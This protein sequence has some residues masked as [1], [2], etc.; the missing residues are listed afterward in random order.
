MKLIKLFEGQ[1]T[2]T[3]CQCYRDCDCTG[4]VH[5]Y[6]GVKYQKPNGQVR[7]KEFPNLEKR[8]EFINKHFNQ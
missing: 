6:F 2:I 8:Q 4:T 3:I 5:K 1:R 7:N